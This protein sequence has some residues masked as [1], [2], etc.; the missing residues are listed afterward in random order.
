MMDFYKT[1]G[2]RRLCDSTL[3]EIAKQLKRVADE[4]KRENRLKEIEL[5]LRK[6][7]PGDVAKEFIEG[8]EI[9]HRNVAPSLPILRDF[10]VE[11]DFVVWVT[12]ELGNAESLKFR[13]KDDLLKLANPQVLKMLRDRGLSVEFKDNDPSGSPTEATVRREHH[14]SD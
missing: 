4:L 7:S 5:G 11:G 13:C 10:R 9:G 6:M 2:G 8:D 1:A 14:D 3:P 12:G